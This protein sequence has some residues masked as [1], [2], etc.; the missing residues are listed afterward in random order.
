LKTFLFP[1]KLRKFILLQLY[2]IK[3]KEAINEILLSK[4]FKDLNFYIRRNLKEI[5]KEP[6]G[7]KKVQQIK[8]D[9][10]D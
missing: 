3:D 2:F 1:K 4:A 5:M 8:E 7:L 6:D 10:T 9:T